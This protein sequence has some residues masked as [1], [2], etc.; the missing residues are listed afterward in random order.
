METAGK[1]NIGIWHSCKSDLLRK[2][3]RIEI[4]EKQDKAKF[5]KNLNNIGY[6]FPNEKKFFFEKTVK[7]FQRH[8][9]KELINGVLDKEC[10]IIAQNLSKKL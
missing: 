2:F 10:L 1:K 7:A 9:R 5:V 6:C 4:S 3:R 8:Y